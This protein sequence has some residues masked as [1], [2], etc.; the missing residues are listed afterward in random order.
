[1]V[2]YILI[3]EN[4]ECD[5]IWKESWQIKLWILRL[6]THVGPKSMTRVLIRETRKRDLKRRPCEDR[7]RNWS[8]AATSKGMPGA[9]GL[10]EARRQSLQG[11]NMTLP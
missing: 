2:A 10:R 7:G 4:S 9:V 8:E 3:Y 5:L 1:M 6:I 11:G